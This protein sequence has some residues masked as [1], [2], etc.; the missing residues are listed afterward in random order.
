MG[1]VNGLALGAI[2]A[3]A[4]FIYG[5]I[6]GKSPLTL[7]LSVVQGKDP[8]TVAQSQ[9]IAGDAV[10]VS[11]DTTSDTP[12][13]SGGAGGT[14]G[15]GTPAT[16]GNVQEIFRNTAAKFGWDKGEQWAALQSLEMHEAGFDPTAHNPSGAF[17]L[18][19]ALGHST[20]GSAGTIENQYGANYGLSTA[21]ARKANSGD[22][23]T[24]ALWMMNYIKSRYGN[25]V[26]TMA[27]YVHA[28]GRSWY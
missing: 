12:D 15:K 9:G 24:Q 5:G 27:Q 4:V 25:P 23:A 21:Q 14:G 17:G 26:N 3:G 16:G 28:D 22:P 10:P 8:K 7:V 13:T 6:A 19:Q 1:E 11:S 18:A 20:P 2:T